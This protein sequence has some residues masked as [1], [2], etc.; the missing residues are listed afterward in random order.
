LLPWKQDE[1][2]ARQL[3]QDAGWH[4][5]FR[6]SIFIST[7]APFPLATQVAEGLAQAWARVGIGAT[8]EAVPQALFLQSAF[9]RK[10]PIFI[11]AFNNVWGT[12]E[13]FYSTMLHSKTEDGR[14]GFL[15]FSYYKNAEVD[16]LIEKG[17]VT[18]DDNARKGMFEQAT[19][20]A[21][22]DAN[23]VPLWHLSVATATKSDLKYTPRADGFLFAMDVKKGG[24]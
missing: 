24:K 8:V 3:L 18:L 21:V 15:N 13:N 6:V 23:F 2:R 10:A 20:L 7:S 14:F 9:Q 4:N 16:S 12:P 19:R 22:Q 17:F 1:A 11:T 5:K